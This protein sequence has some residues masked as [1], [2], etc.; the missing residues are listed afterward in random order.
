MGEA[1]INIVA[2]VT[3]GDSDNL[4]VGRNGVFYDRAG[5]DWD[6]SVVKII[7]NPV[8][9]M[10]AFWS[11][12]KRAIKWFSELVAKYTSTADTKV[13]EN[14]TESVLPPKASTKVEIKKIDVG[15]V[16]ALGVAET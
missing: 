16:A 3:A 13:V 15:T 12:Y 7:H 2:V 9:L 8:S 14:L 10:Q 1:D 5:R 4:V 11:P 6:A